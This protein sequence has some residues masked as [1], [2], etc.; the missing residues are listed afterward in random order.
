MA[1]RRQALLE[2]R[3]ALPVASPP[4]DLSVPEQ[5]RPDLGHGSGRVELG[6][7]VSRRDGAL[8]LL[9]VRLA[10]HDLLD[11]PDGYPRTA[12]IEFVDL[13]LRWAPRPHRLELDEGWLVRITSL[14][15][16]TRLEA[17]P[18]WK[19]RFGAATVRDAACPGC[20]VGDLEVGG[21]LAA[22]GLL[23]AA[24]LLATGDV[25]LQGAPG[26]SGFRGRGVRLGLG[27]GGLLRVAAGERLALAAEARWRWWAEAAPSRSWLLRAEA[28]A[29][30]TPW[31]SLALEAR[32][33]PLDDEA[34]ALLHLFY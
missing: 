31:L 12:Q 29:H 8:V 28:R 25:E 30:L 34:V 32:R 19:A 18:S 10:F 21:G 13:R 20:L 16:L 5:R 7:G 27:P 3:A 24:D 6:G 4:L 22:M 14:S 11:P 2:R 9:D 15:A 23:G 17:R 1:R 33:T 26:L